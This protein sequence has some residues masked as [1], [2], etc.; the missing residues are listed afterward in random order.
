MIASPLFLYSLRQHDDRP[1]ARPSVLLMAQSLGEGLDWALYFEARRYF[2]PPTRVLA[3]TNEARQERQ[4]WK[5][6][7]S[8]SMGCGSAI[9]SKSVACEQQRAVPGPVAHAIPTLKKNIANRS[10]GAA[11]IARGP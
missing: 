3:A 7:N 2:V 8:A 10:T 4:H 6:P 9:E 1:I 5:S 11:I